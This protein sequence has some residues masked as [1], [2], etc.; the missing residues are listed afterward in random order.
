M[1]QLPRRT[2]LRSAVM[3][4]FS[5]KLLAALELQQVGERFALIF[6][7]LP[8]NHFDPMA[9]KLNPTIQALSAKIN[10]LEADNKAKDEKIAKMEQRILHLE[11]SID[12]L[13]QHGRR[14]SVKIFGLPEDNPGTTDDKKSSNSAMCRWPFLIEL[15]NRSQFRSTPAPSLHPHTH[16][17]L[18]LWAGEPRSM[19][20]PRERRC[21]TETQRGCE[22]TTPRKMTNLMTTWSTMRIELYCQ[23]YSWQR[24]LLRL[25]LALRTKHRS[26]NVT[27]KFKIPG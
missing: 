23:Q 12:D 24:I 4:D 19:W 17:S 25:V 16:S 6:E 21:R 14:D 22:L 1:S 18:N 9:S 10:T 2:R 3:E 7:P 15:E 26:S 20:W 5:T 27:T 11:S 13:E 8:K